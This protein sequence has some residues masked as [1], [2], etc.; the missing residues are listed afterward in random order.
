MSN[1][2]STHD[3]TR[4]F[5]GVAALNLVNLDISDKQVHSIIGPNGAG[6]TTLINVITGRLD[7]SGGS[8]IYQ[9]KDITNRPVH[10]RVRLGLS[11]TFQITSIFMGLSVRE[12]VRIAK[13]SQAGGNLR[14]FSHRN[15]LK[16]VN[17]ATEA[18]IERVGLGD[19]AGVPAKNLAHG[20]QR[21]LEVAIALAGNP[22][23]ILLDEPAAGMSPTETDQ[24]S[25]LISSLGQEMSVLLVEHDMEVV[26]SISH[27]VTVLHQGG[28]IA[29][30]TPGEISE[31][32]EVKRAYLGTE[33]WAPLVNL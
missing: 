19:V 28:I 13:Q 22:K 31:N 30:G 33:K 9:G 32:D 8:V 16:Q 5:G 12:N 3:L 18:I 15:K 11:R 26:M 29:D 27:R 14:I 23:L 10:E 20:D 1:I 6:K 2:L 4:N 17:Q 25:E 21:V 7:A 24:I